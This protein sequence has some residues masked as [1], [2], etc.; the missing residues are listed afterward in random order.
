MSWSRKVLWKV[1]PYSVNRRFGVDETVK[2]RKP[3][4]QATMARLDA[5][6]AQ[7][8]AAAEAPGLSAEDK[9]AA[10]AK[11][12]AREKHLTPAYQSVALEF[13]DLRESACH[14]LHS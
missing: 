2:Y 4:V 1:S 8:K 11:L 3:K 10:T 6:Y 14:V 5:E 13:A 12:E 7:L 9:A